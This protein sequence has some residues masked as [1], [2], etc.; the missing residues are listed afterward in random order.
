MKR[1][2]TKAVASFVATATMMIALSGSVN[3]VSQTDLVGVST[4]EMPAVA[5]QLVANAKADQREEV[6]K[7]VITSAMSQKPNIAPSLVGAIAKI[8]PEMAPIAAVTAATLDSKQIGQIVKAA[9]LAAQSQAGKIVAAVCEKF[10]TQYNLVAMAAYEAAP[11]AGKEI[12][13]AEVASV[14]TLKSAFG[15]ATAV[16]AAIAQSQQYLESNSR[17]MNMSAEKILAPAAISGL[18][19][20][21]VSQSALSAGPIV[22]GPATAP[23]GTPVNNSSTTPVVPGPSRPSNYSL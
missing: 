7:S 2:S 23:V 12:L 20:T 3:A 6:V 9:T 10:P 8:S 21:E 15:S 16:P 17:I 1:N 5:A 22:G 13:A 18:P 4:T 11:K 14:P 19:Y